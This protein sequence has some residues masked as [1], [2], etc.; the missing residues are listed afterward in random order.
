MVKFKSPGTNIIKYG[1]FHVNYGT[2]WSCKEKIT[3]YR[4]IHRCICFHCHTFTYAI[5]DNICPRRCWWLSYCK[6][7]FCGIVYIS[8]LVFCA[9]KFWPERKDRIFSRGSN[10]RTLNTKGLIITLYTLLD[11]I[12]PYITNNFSQFLLFISNNPLASM[13]AHTKLCSRK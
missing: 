11:R 2:Q 12:F 3:N 13:N 4:I 5:I 6:E 10:K 9:C 1:R 8:L 7:I